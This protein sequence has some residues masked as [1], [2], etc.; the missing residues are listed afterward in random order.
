MERTLAEVLAE[1]RVSGEESLLVD[2][3]T[4]QSAAAV[5]G[6]ETG[7]RGI[8][9]PPIL[10]DPASMVSI[11]MFHLYR[12]RQLE[13]ASDAFAAIGFAAAARE[14]RPDALPP[15][16]ADLLARVAQQVEKIRPFVSAGLSSHAEVQF[17]AWERDGQAEHLDLAIGAWC[18]ALN[19]TTAIH[20]DRALWQS[21]LA[22]A[23]LARYHRERV[24]DDLNRA[25]EV[26]QQ[27]VRSPVSSQP[28]RQAVLF[29]RV[30]VLKL[31]DSERKGEAPFLDM[32]IAASLELL[33]THTQ[34]HEGSIDWAKTHVTASDLL[35]RRFRRDAKDDD[36]NAAIAQCTSALS[37]ASPD[38]PLL[39]QFHVCLAQ[40]LEDRYQ[41]VGR[42]ADLDAA[43]TALQSAV[44]HCPIRDANLPILLF[45]LGRVHRR[46]YDLRREP[47]DA[48]E[49][50][51]AARA[52]VD[53]TGP[54]DRGIGAALGNL[55][56][57]LY[58]RFQA[59]R[60]QA[61]LDEAVGHLRAATE[62]GVDLDD[63]ALA[64][65]NLC[66][67]LRTRYDQTG[68]VADLEAAVEAGRKAVLIGGNKANW[69]YKLNLALALCARYNA[70]LNIADLDSAAEMLEHDR[71]LSSAIRL[72]P[73]WLSARGI[74]FSARY[75]ATGASADLDAAVG[76][77]LDALA[78][79]RRL[80]GHLGFYLR[81]AG[82]VLLSR[83]ERTHDESD[84]R[85]GTELCL[86]AVQEAENTGDEASALSNYAS[87]MSFSYER[88]RLI[89]D[90]DLAI[91]AGRAAVAAS[92]AGSP[93][94]AAYLANLAGR[95]LV[96]NQTE[97]DDDLLSDAVD[98]AREA[99]SSL[100]AG[101]PGRYMALSNLAQLLR[102]RWERHGDVEAGDESHALFLEAATDITAPPNEQVRSAG[103]RGV[104]AALLGDWD[105]A[106]AGYT[107]ALKK[108]EIAAWYGLTREDRLHSIDLV[109][110]LA[111]DAAAAA[112]QSRRAGMALQLMEQGRAFVAGQEM[113]VNAR[114]ADLRQRNPDLARSLEEMLI[115]IGR[116]FGAQSSDRF[117]EHRLVGELTEPVTSQN[118][119]ADRR[120]ALAREWD[121]LVDDVR[122]RDGFEDFLKP[123]RLETLLSAA[124][125]GPIA[126]INVSRWRCDALLVR[127]SGVEVEELPDL[128]LDSVVARANQYL[129]VLYKVDG[130]ARELYLARQR[131]ESDE[132]TLAATR[133]YT[134]A[135][136]AWQ[137]ARDERDSTLE[138]VLHWLWDTVAEPVLNA[139]GF[140]RTPEPGEDWP[141]LWWCPTGPLA[142][143]PLHAAGY[144]QTGIGRTVLD[145][146]A[147]SYT[148]TLRALLEARR[149][150]DASPEHERMLIVSLADTPDEV[151]LDD[152]VRERNLLISLFSSSHTLLDGKA[153]TASAVIEQLP[154]HRWAHFSCHGGQNLADP[155]RGGLLL[156]DRILTIADI[157]ARQ[158]EGEFAFLSACMTAVGGVNLPDEAIT[159]TAALHYT[160]YRQLI[161]TM[162]TVYDETA[163]DVAEAVYADLTSTGQFEPS[164]AA[165][166]LHTAIRHLR[167]AK[168]LPPGDWSPFTHTGP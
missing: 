61:D 65:S 108:L 55:G 118:R 97:P 142:V 3:S 38:H 123:P 46:R 124:S 98:T 116:A 127:A 59:D 162:W 88:T 15:P 100:V 12:Y 102:L 50:E 114:L 21:N 22:T 27:A 30:A 147:S 40:R 43:V 107:D 93:L 84:L 78:E 1:Y 16:L 113:V 143:L 82:A 83:Y 58:A 48:V 31:A 81:N 2:L 92:P 26:S 18:A 165:V 77:Y 166:A 44:Q 57:A 129:Q 56:L 85:H 33:S 148:P 112:L 120:L 104:M 86:A 53:A 159:L 80:G 6:I 126:T 106:V 9:P 64:L 145:R 19:S 52:A 62:L 115:R 89:N 111:R 155:S 79:A 42:P 69:S 37:V 68:A 54:G 7:R 109:E 47:I 14:Q 24:D 66:V 125:S 144:H 23:L 136:Q 154:R 168:H 35:H 141:R 137:D 90:L 153:A 45:R 51:R 121:R 146:V 34:Q 103:R 151:P 87:A 49:S 139:L 91:D 105:D 28:G 128:T 138:S 156:H 134:E 133:Q 99:V 39:Y 140:H 20:Q 110:G 63:R 158:H 135:K 161:G 5:L 150:L 117:Q 8:E 131:L 29:T 122:K 60:R 67:V 4:M 164:Y 10:P 17:A 74:V 95:L 70:T 130:A 36:L 73:Q 160:G 157:S 149:P 71:T 119:I 11:A 13:T 72:D 94:R 41:R 25:L 96:R 32:A 167:D 76:A 152:V 75:R 163:A 132:Q 101:Y